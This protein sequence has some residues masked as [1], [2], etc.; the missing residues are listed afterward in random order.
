MPQGDDAAT[1]ALETPLEEPVG[2]LADA[3][4]EKEEEVP[5]PTEDEPA[6]DERSVADMMLAGM[7]SRPAEVEATQAVQPA[8]RP[9]QT[10][11]ELVKEVAD[12]IMV[13]NTGP[14]GA[15]EVRIILKDEV[16]GGSEVRISEH[17]GAIQVTFVAETKD[18][19][20]FLETHREDIAVALG[21]RLDRTVEVSV[22]DRNSDDTGGD[23][24][25]Q[26]GQDA[27]QEGGQ[28]DSGGRSRN[29]RDVRDERE[30]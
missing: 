9:E 30:R 18:A 26:G 15:K 7:T 2:R 27:R 29:R 12:R 22:M 25:G 3:E 4:P 5:A 11:S 19:E 13:G 17:A 10:L 20:Q 14:D 24:P 21:E 28:Q 23:N 6:E 1:P 8:Q 16:L